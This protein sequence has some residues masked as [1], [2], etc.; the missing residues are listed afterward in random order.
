MYLFMWSLFVL[1]CLLIG[2]CLYAHGQ[3][4]QDA[5]FLKRMMAL[6]IIILIS[7]GLYLL[8][9]RPKS[10][11]ELA[12]DGKK[13]ANQI[14]GLADQIR[15]YEL[16]IEGT[17]DSS[18]KM[19]LQ[20]H[21]AHLIQ[22]DADH[23]IKPLID[24]CTAKITHSPNP[25][26]LHRQQALQKEYDSASARAN[27][28]V[29]DI[30]AKLAEKEK[31]AFQELCK[32]YH[33]M[34]NCQKV[35]LITSRTTNTEYKSSASSI[36]NRTSIALLRGAFFDI[37]T[38][39][40]IPRIPLGYSIYCYF[41][42]RFVIVGS[43]LDTFTVYKY[44]QIQIQYTS[45]RFIE[46]GTVPSD[47]TKV[48]TTY[49]YVNKNG[50][51]DRRYSYNPQRPV[52][53]YGEVTIPL[54]NYC[55]QVSNYSTAENFVAAFDTYKNCLPVQEEDSSNNKTAESSNSLLDERQNE[56]TSIYED[57]TLSQVAKYVITRE[58]VRASEIMRLLGL[59]YR[60]SS[61]LLERLESLG[62]IGSLP[63]ASGYE[64][65]IKDPAKLDVILRS[66]SEGEPD[67][68]VSEQYYNDILDATQRLYVFCEQLG[69]EEAFCEQVSNKVNGEIKWSGRLVTAP[70]EQIPIFLLSDVLRAYEGLGH[71]IDLSTIEGLGLFL[72]TLYFIKPGYRPDYRLLGTIRERL[73]E[74]TEGVLLTLSSTIKVSED[75]FIIEYCLKE[76][77]NKLHNQYVVLLYRMASLIAKA[78][79]KVT[80]LEAKWLGEIISLKLPEDEDGIIQPN[81]T[82]EK[83]PEK[84]SA[85]EI[86][87][88]ALSSLNSLIGLESVKS[89]IT[90][91]TNYIK[92][93]NLRSEK[94][95]K[96]SPISYHCVFTGNPGTGKT[97]V[98]RI[99]AE[100]YKDLGI[101]KKGHLVETDRSG[102]VAEYVGQTAGKTNKI[103]DSALDG[104]LFIDE[105]YSLVDGGSSDYGKEA[106]ATLL[107]RMED[108]RKRLVVILAG[109]T[110]DMKRFIDSNPGLQS[111]FNRYIEF[112]DYSAEE[113]LQ[114]FELNVKK[115][116]YCLTERAITV[117]KEML[118]K[119]VSN[120]DKNFGNGR[121]VRNLFEKVIENQANRISLAAD[122]SADSLARI[123]EEDILRSAQC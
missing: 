68:R 97:T 79:K 114:I 56:K 58:R 19:I 84:G 101:L 110:A 113:L 57:D 2:F 10:K 122:I 69:K 42:P 26:L 43:S 37:D 87:S 24:K 115:Y 85:R 35:W 31:V 1:S 71:L 105:A 25:E 76:Y 73:E 119:A 11:A 88:S 54:L 78:D 77:D 103:I 12:Y 3:H 99:V 121:Y 94:G 46:D 27:D 74:Q 108:D 28:L 51:P 120:K 100:I 52:M 66:Y 92:V 80:A 53:L 29:L 9:S 59:G 65:L 6:S 95:M 15:K 107:K 48:G 4:D 49:M 111:R 86:R 62:V 36:L 91:L 34:Q 18:R 41:Y 67:K 5:A 93:Q 104:V 117:L 50:G 112:P 38:C 70:K 75:A 64:V 90:T 8:I 16:K 89:E 17:E 23:R 21:L 45:S 96:V 39:Y 40:D 61:V 118:D 13:R 14:K 106:V 102:L 7:S 109:Y 55:I 20:N 116:E 63:D 47:S 81:I 123:E 22:E 83:S 72:F 32:A 30:D 60:K 44:S 33:S 82:V 98:A